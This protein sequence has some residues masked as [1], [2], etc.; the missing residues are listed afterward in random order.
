MGW[1]GVSLCS[2]DA[3]QD[4]RDR[5]A[6]D[7]SETFVCRPRDMSQEEQV[8][9]VVAYIER[10]PPQRLSEDFWVLASEAIAANFPCL[11]PYP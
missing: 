6:A 5:L 4:S 7:L 3:G 2:G 8:Q 9:S 10:Q 11:E 1:A